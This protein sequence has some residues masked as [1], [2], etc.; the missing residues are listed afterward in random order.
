MGKHSSI[1]AR[2]DLHV[3]YLDAY[4]ILHEEI[5]YEILP[6][7]TLDLRYLHDHPQ[8]TVY[9]NLFANTVG[10]SNPDTIGTIPNVLFSEV[11]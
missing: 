2:V 6:D 9:C 8:L 10:P 1:I 7:V 5:N 4:G 11:S 3:L